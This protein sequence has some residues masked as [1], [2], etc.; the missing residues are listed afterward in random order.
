MPKKLFCLLLAVLLLL[1]VSP[2]ARAEEELCILLSADLHFTQKPEK[3]LQFLLH[4]YDKTV[5]I[6]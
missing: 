4:I 1:P 6:R 3:S 2:R 5:T